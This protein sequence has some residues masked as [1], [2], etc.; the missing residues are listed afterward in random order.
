LFPGVSQIGA[1][2]HEALRNDQKKKEQ[3]ALKH[4]QK[5]AARLAIKRQ[6]EQRDKEGKKNK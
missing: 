3:K 1:V 4:A 6:K 2:V 5:K